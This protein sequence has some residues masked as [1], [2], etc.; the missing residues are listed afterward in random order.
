MLLLVLYICVVLRDL[1]MFPWEC[2]S[3]KVCRFCLEGPSLDTQYKFVQPCGCKGTISWV[4]ID[5]LF[6]WQ[7]E[8][9]QQKQGGCSV[10]KQPW[11]IR[12]SSLQPLFPI[13][14]L[15]MFVFIMCSLSDTIVV[16]PW[17]D[18]VTNLTYFT[19]CNSM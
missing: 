2:T 9:R 10:C 7:R 13:R 6:R 5:C 8:P 15:C 18:A 17:I 14:F 12:P 16:S 1:I 19:R 11:L 4:H 3:D